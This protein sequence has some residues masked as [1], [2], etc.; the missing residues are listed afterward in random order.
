[1]GMA[2]TGRL[3]FLTRG[4]LPGAGGE[5]SAAASSSASAGASADA[6]PAKKPRAAPL[7]SAELGAPLVHG[8]FVTAC[9]APPD[10]KVVVKVAVKLGRAVDVKVTTDPPDPMIA[11]CI[12]K[13]TRDL[14]WEPS[15]K[16]DHVTV[17]Y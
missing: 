17:R 2:A 12:D 5:G 11:A 1:A 15:R 7:S 14:Q 3:P 16:T 10:M 13:A 8:A 9:G 6:G 4:W